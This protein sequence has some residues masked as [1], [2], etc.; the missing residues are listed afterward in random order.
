MRRRKQVHRVAAQPVVEVTLS[1]ESLRHL[2]YLAQFGIYGGTAGEV[3]ARFIDAA[4][5]EFMSPPVLSPAG[6]R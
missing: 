5:Q 2:A 1:R 3:A 4:L 6:D